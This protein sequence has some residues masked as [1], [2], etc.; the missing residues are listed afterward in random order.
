MLFLV[1]CFLSP[2]SQ[3]RLIWKLNPIEKNFVEISLEFHGYVLS[4]LHGTSIADYYRNQ[5]DATIG[6]PTLFITGDTF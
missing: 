4:S 3:P 2:C 1:L 6:P 5:V